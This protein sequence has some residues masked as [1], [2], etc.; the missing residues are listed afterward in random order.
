[1]TTPMTT[2]K[3]ANGGP[4]ISQMTTDKGAKDGHKPTAVACLPTGRQDRE[5]VKICVICGQKPKLLQDS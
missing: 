1:M 2:D 3:G 4:Q 5:S